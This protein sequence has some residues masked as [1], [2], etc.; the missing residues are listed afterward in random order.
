MVFTINEILLLIL[1][2]VL[3]IVG[4][5]LKKAYL[6]IIAGMLLVV[7][8]LSFTWPFWT[9]ILISFL[10]MG[11]VFLGAFTRGKK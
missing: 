7:I 4:S 3:L 10:G 9:K 6:I 2:F 11:I 8:G 5:A 1:P